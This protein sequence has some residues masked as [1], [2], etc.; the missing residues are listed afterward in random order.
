[1]L[2]GKLPTGARCR[3]SLE[4]QGALRCQGSGPTDLGICGPA[5]ESGTCGTAVDAL[6]GLLQ[7][8]LDRSHPAC[9][10]YC[11]HYHCGKA[12][13]EGEACTVNLQCARGTHCGKGV[14]EPGDEAPLGAPCLGAPCAGGARCTGGVCALPKA[15]G[16]ACHHP[17]ECRGGCL[18]GDAGQGTCGMRCDSR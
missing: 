1:V 8:N 17:F 2:T 4:C 9:A 3:S 11:D 6:A 5:R 14:C 13:A 10:G 18:M 16:E 15:A 7:I 12:K